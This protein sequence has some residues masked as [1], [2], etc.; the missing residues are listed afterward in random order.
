MW[1]GKREADKMLIMAW[2]V[3][4][5]PRSEAQWVICKDSLTTLAPPAPTGRSQHVF[6]QCLLVAK[7]VFHLN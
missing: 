7:I 4:V 6:R 5:G 3:T 2:V 1:G